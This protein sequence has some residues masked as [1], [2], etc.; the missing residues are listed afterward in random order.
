MALLSAEQVEQ[1]RNVDLLTYLQTHEPYSIRKSGANEYC[2]VEHDS[3]K[4]SNG[5]FNWFS[6]GFG[7]Y[8]ALDFLIKVRGL[9]FPEAVNHLAGGD[10]AYSPPKP[11]PKVLK[12]K[13]PKAFALPV[14]NINNDKAIAYLR[15]RGVDNDIIR[16]CIKGGLL[17]EAAKSHNCVF[18]GYK[19]KKAKFAC[20]RGISDDYKK[21]VYGSDKRFNFTLP[22]INPNSTKLMVMESPIDCL[23]HASIHKLDGNKWDGYRLSL[24]GVSSLA[25][26]SFLEQY[27]EIKGVQLGLDND[28]AGQKATNRIIKELLSDNRFSHLKISI[29]PP[30]IGKDYCDTL[31][32]I[33]QLNKE[34]STQ[35]RHAAL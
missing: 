35:N 15:G 22:P 23:S 12:E 1:A 24:G 20:E 3:L 32:A 21:D 26:I 9:D 11:P 34:K 10:V 5:K 17:Y 25:L 16:Q 31:G 29:V 19:G 28:K 27:P 13:P 4:I 6:R 8:S 2:L 14:A 7:G 30:P 33:L 18:V